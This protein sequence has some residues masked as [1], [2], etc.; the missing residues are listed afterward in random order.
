MWCGDL[1]VGICWFS[2][3][4]MCSADRLLGSFYSPE[5]WRPATYTRLEFRRR[6]WL[7]LCWSHA[8]FC[9]RMCELLRPS[10]VWRTRFQMALLAA[11][12]ILPWPATSIHSLISSLNWHLPGPISMATTHHV[13]SVWLSDWLCQYITRGGGCST[14]LDWFG[15]E[16]GGHWTQRLLMRANREINLN[17]N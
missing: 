13:L 2:V 9:T 4:A 11:F 17:F 10:R 16:G 5:S 7:W 6:R 14:E 1:N 8:R 15:S 12:V 3:C